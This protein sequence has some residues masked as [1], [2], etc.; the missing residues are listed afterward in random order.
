MD[1]PKI[2]ANSKS[3]GTK[4]T[5][6]ETATQS[7]TSR[8]ALIG[9]SDS[10]AEKDVVSNEEECFILIEI[11]NK[12]DLIELRNRSEQDE[13]VKESANESL[14]IFGKDSFKFN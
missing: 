4:V 14:S 13:E 10:V 6:G 8:F 11:D 7:P 2:E 12:Q 1:T 3:S 9:K 5:E